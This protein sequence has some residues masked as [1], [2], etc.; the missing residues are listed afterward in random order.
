MVLQS[1]DVVASLRGLAFGMGAGVTFHGWD[2]WVEFTG[3]EGQSG[4]A[5]VTAIGRNYVYGAERINLNDNA[6]LTVDRDGLA[7]GGFSGIHVM[8]LRVVFAERKGDCERGND[9]TR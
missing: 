6:N 4:D 1:A 3:L 7:D 5:K 8:F 9:K 2:F